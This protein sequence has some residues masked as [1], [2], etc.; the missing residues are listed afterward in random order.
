MVMLANRSFGGCRDH[1][2]VGKGL[3]KVFKTHKSELLSLASF[4]EEGTARR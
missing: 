1:D 4:V 3:R 2:A